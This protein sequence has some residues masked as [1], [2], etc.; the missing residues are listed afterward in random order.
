MCNVSL[1]LSKWH[2]T[3]LIFCYTGY[4]IN[5]QFPVGNPLGISQNWIFFKWRPVASLYPKCLAWLF[6]LDSAPRLLDECLCIKPSVKNV[7][8]LLTYP[9]NLAFWSLLSEFWAVSL[10]VFFFF[11][12]LG[13]VRWWCWVTFGA[14]RPAVLDNGRARALSACSRLMGRGVGVTMVLSPIISLSF[15][16]LSIDWNAISTGR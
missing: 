15:L 10:I 8:C 5:Q 6:F 14:G 16:P 1:L 9:R 11:A 13:R 2:K 3:A 7:Y 12:I 4:H